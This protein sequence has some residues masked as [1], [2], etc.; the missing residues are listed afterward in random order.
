MWPLITSVG[1]AL[2]GYHARLEDPSAPWST[3]DAEQVDSLVMVIEDL[4][5]KAG[6]GPTDHHHGSTGDNG[7]LAELYEAPLSTNG[8]ADVLEGLSERAAMVRE[9]AW[10]RA[11]RPTPTYR[12]ASDRSDSLLITPLDIAVPQGGAVPTDVITA[13][14]AAEPSAEPGGEPPPITP[15]EPDAAPPRIDR[16][17]VAVELLTVVGILMFLFVIYAV[18]GSALDEAQSQRHLDRELQGRLRASVSLGTGAEDADSGLLGQPEETEAEPEQEVELA[19]GPPG[20]GD[21][22]AILSLPTIGMR[23]VVVEGTRSTDLTAGPGHLRSSPLPGQAGNS[24]VFGRRTTFGGPF[25]ELDQLG[26]GA[27]MDVVTT[28]GSFRYV[29]QEVRL[30]NDG[31]P[32]PITA[33]FSNRLTLVTSDEPYETSGRLVAIG[34]LDGVPAPAPVDEATDSPA[35]MVGPDELGTKRS[36]ADGVVA[37][38]W[39]QVLVAAYFGARWLYRHWLPWST[40]LVSTPVILLVGLGWLESV[41]RLLPSTL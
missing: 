9:Q 29:L 32:D 24:V 30:V 3:T 1:E 33:T 2:D 37:L 23:E 16:G 40:W 22:V 14:P 6:P 34:L 7:Q 20:S 13:E 4:R 35:R 10:D 21:P 18:F 26:P 5:S 12:P 31:D 15:A 39:T 8:F 36:A 25:A 19:T 28:D 11:G 38:L 41:T 17:A 27:P